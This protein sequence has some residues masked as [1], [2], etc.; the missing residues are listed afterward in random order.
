M[1]L[2]PCP[3]E[4]IQPNNSLTPGNQKNE[5]LTVHSKVNYIA[6]RLTRL[7]LH[8]SNLSVSKIQKRGLLMKVFGRWGIVVFSFTL[9]LVICPSP[10]GFAHD[11][12]QAYIVVGES[13]DLGTGATVPEKAWAAMLHEFLESKFFGSPADFHNYAVFGATVGD[14]LRGQLADALSDIASHN[15]VVVSLGGGGNDLLQFISSPQA[16]TCLM[17]NLECVA[18][19]NALLNNMEALFDQMVRKLRAAGPNIPILLRTEHNP[20]LKESCGGPT[21]GLAQLANLVLEGSDNAPFLASGLNDRIR[22]VAARY[23]GKVIETFFSFA[24]NPD[25]LV[26]D[27][28]IHPND[29]G[30]E[31]ICEAAVAVFDFPHKKNKNPCVT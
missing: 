15:P 12:G 26:S 18:R 25:D 24:S 6:P 31:V 10:E 22:D 30:H 23:N 3:L 2:V 8:T 27:D 29:A 9:Y 13:T 20:L 1:D 21:D 28:C 16:V 17:V 7:D 4:N 14:I 19:L 11:T 5:E